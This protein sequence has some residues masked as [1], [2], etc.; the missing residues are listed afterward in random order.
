MSEYGLSGHESVAPVICNNQVG[1]VS[2]AK[3]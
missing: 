1:A 3:F 2:F